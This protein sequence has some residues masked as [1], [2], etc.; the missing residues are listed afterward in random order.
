MTCLNNLNKTVF[1][2][3]L[4]LFL[5]FGFLSLLS[6][7]EKEAPKAKNGH[8]ASFLI[9][10]KET[11][12]QDFVGVDS[13][14]ANGYNYKKILSLKV[15]LKDIA[16][17]KTIASTD[18]KV[19]AGDIGVVKTTDA[20]GC[21]IWKE[22]V[23]FDPAESDRTVFMSRSI[24]ATERHVG[25]VDFDFSFNPSLTKAQ[26]VLYIGQ[27]RSAADKISAAVYQTAELNQKSGKNFD[28]DVYVNIIG[29]N[30][31]STASLNRHQ[32]VINTLGLNFKGI[33]YQNL[34]VDQNLNLIFPYNYVTDMSISLLKQN[35]NQIAEE[36][37]RM[38][39][40]MFHLVFLK[41][42]SP[43]KTARAQDVYSAVEFKGQ[44]RGDLGVINVPITL[45]F[46]N[47]PA[48]A[49]RMSVLMTV[50]SL[51]Q[52][53]LFTDQTFEGV[54]NGVSANQRLEILFNGSDSSARELYAN[55]LATK[56]DK[57]KETLKLDE[58]LK[59]E[60][61][62]PAES[63]KVTYTR[64]N[65]STV[66]R[67]LSS[68]IRGLVDI[69]S[70]DVLDLEALC[71]VVF[72]GSGN[73]Q[74][75]SA[76]QDCL[77]RPQSVLVAEVREYVKSLKSISNVYLLPSETFTMTST[78][79]MDKGYEYK[80]GAEGEASFGVGVNS[81]DPKK[82]SDSIP[83]PTSIISKI[84]EYFIP[85]VKYGIG[86]K[87][88]VSGKTETS[89]NNSTNLTGVS[90]EKLISQRIVLDM[91]VEVQKCLLLSVSATYKKALEN[92]SFSTEKYYC[93]TGV[94]RESRSESY[95]LLNHTQSDPSGLVDQY[96]QQASPLRMM[97][98]GEKVY[99]NFR[100]HLDGNIIR[101]TAMDTTKNGMSS[102]MTEESALMLSSGRKIIIG[103]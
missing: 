103:Q 23:E 83:S 100:K 52:P 15:C 45:N 17:T 57:Q 18:F 3:V 28:Y 58:V 99:E 76:Y 60:G 88:F 12:V 77:A 75:E 1:T 55:Y 34:S 63:E 25:S 62:W 81:P 90:Q 87:I 14:N 82:P 48:L 33:D 56:V 101:W 64:S 78:F 50:S 70:L 2:R 11:A 46:D 7:S 24:Q 91:D 98:R 42:L 8:G 16:E 26:I 6:C 31:S 85:F 5:A 27:G 79:S 37:I 10:P 9:D 71:K 94:V 66:T 69:K 49:S 44:A 74:V 21:L 61:F 47:I 40:F 65:K 96:A 80:S 73:K 54:V 53:A 93:A 68:I 41:T 92:N 38:G 32:T 4:S 35:L 51:D 102:F 89:K 29:S 86:G 72:T 95:F 13:Q 20:F 59:F 43:G 22:L 19:V 30:K 84:G 36:K 39:R 97:L 67:D